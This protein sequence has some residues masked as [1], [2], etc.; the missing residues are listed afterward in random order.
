M[1]DDTTLDDED[2]LQA[3][4]VIEEAFQVSNDEAVSMAEEGQ[5]VQCLAESFEDYV[6]NYQE[7]WQI[8]WERS[9][10]SFEQGVQDWSDNLGASWPDRIEPKPG[11]IPPPAPSLDKPAAPAKG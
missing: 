5:A 8:E 6:R 10:K 9:I 2:E 7:T 4:I 3:T 1:S 11:P